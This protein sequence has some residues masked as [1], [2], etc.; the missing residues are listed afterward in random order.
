M[1]QSKMTILSFSNYMEANDT[2]LF[3]ELQL[4]VGINRDILIKNILINAGD[5]EILYSNP[6]FMQEAIG[7]WSQKWER[8][9][10]RWVEVLNIDYD[11]LTNYDR[12]EEWTDDNHR[13][14]DGNS[15]TTDDSNGWSKMIIMIQH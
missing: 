10:R 1:S 11:P 8:T 12:H 14:G 15:K 7:V 5:F 9:F 2:D 4:P 6:Y 3:S 13:W